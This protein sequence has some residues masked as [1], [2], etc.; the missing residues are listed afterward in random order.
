MKIKNAF[1]KIYKSELYAKESLKKV[2][3]FPLI[4][5]VE[6]TNV[7]NLFCVMCAR[8]VMKRN[9]GFMELRLFKEILRQ[10]AKS[11]VCS[12]IRFNGYGE[13]LLHKDFFE[14]AAL[15]K[16][17]GFLVHVNSNGMCLNKRNIEKLLSSGVDSIKFSFQGTNKK[18]FER[19]RRGAN[20]EK[21]RQGIKSLI[22][23]R[24]FLRLKH[25]FVQ[26][27][28]TILD[29][30]KED[31][32]RFLAD[33]RKIV[34]DAYYVYTVTSRVK[35]TPQYRDLVKRDVS[36]A[37]TASCMEV[38]TKMN[39][40]WNGDVSACC[41]DYNGKL[42]IGNMCKESLYDIWHGKKASRIRRILHRNEKA[43]LPVCRD[44]HSMF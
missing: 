44:C 26:I 24:N 34:D 14:M 11:G 19:M 3:S 4:L 23:R 42:L 12:A 20:Y 39:L 18:E 36:T 33:W 25:P 9:V 27:A 28:T 16:K 2:L 21:F 40:F 32:D 22:K 6:I 10:A 8:N 43:K 17:E 29:E 13:Q 38:R 1:Q 30:R 41:A 15:A 5:D 31:V 37:R 35:N 7:C